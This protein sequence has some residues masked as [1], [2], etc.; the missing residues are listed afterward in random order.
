MRFA[1]LAVLVACSSSSPAPTTTT[2]ESHRPSDTGAV[3]EAQFKAMHELPTTGPAQRKGETIDLAGGK[4]YL[5]LPAGT[6][7]FPAIIVIHEWWGLNANIEHWADRLAANGWAAIAVDLYGKVTTTKEDAMAAMKAVDDTKA[8]ATITAAIE[9]VAKDPRITATKKAVIGWCFGGGWS[10]QTALAHPELDGA[11]MYYGQ[12]ENDVAKLA[13]IKAR[14]LGIFGE[15]D[16]GIP[17]AK[18]KEFEGALK[19]AGVRAEIHEYDAAHGFANPSNPKYDEKNAGDA[20]QRVLAFL[21][22]LRG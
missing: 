7:P 16:E 11:I 5:S 21:T 15:K 4:A 20:W 3:T 1:L 2:P 19:T 12:L 17:P 18:V 9:F 22:V 14:V 10:L 6:G 8:A 13:T